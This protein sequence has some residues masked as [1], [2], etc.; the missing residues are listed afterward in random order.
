MNLPNSGPAAVV[1]R[2]LVAVNAHDLDGMV[3]CFAEDYVNEAPL[4]PLRGFKGNKQVR[5]NWALIFASVPDLRARLPRT[6]V[7]GDTLWTEWDISGTRTDGTEFLMGGVVI[8]GVTG[9]VITSA[10]FY[11]DAVEGTGG[12]VNAH[13]R[14]VAGTTTSSAGAAGATS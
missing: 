1:E 2:L 13:V 4:H 11:L 3:S 9:T 10:R 7:D 5:A 6:A 14:Q 12:D 8:F